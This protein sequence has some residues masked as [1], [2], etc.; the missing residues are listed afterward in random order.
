MGKYLAIILISFLINTPMGMLV[1]R[2][3]K[4]AL[5]LLYIH[6]PVPVLI[7]LRKAWQLEKS[8]IVVII[9]FAIL[10][11]FAG[12]WVRKQKFSSKNLDRNISS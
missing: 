5:K 11:L 4:M 8:F 9:L 7:L 12:K 3:K 6:L 2:S 10:G 1:A